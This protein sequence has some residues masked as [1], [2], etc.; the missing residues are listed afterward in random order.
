MSELII[1]L[2]GGL[3]DAVELSNSTKSRL[4]TA[5]ELYTGQSILVVGAGPTKSPPPL[6]S[7]GF[8]VFESVAAVRYLL[9]R[10]VLPEHVLYESSSY[11]TI[12][13]A[14]FARVIHFDPAGYTK[15]VIITSAFHLP[16]TKVIFDWIFGLDITRC[17]ELSYVPAYDGHFSP[18]ALAT[19][20][21]KENDRMT[22]LELLMPQM[23]TLAELHRWLFNEHEAY[24]VH[25]QPLP[26]SETTLEANLLLQRD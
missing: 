20:Q 24:S 11:D 18:K 21:H 10:G 16:R 1:V 12:G 23:T 19:H 26:M 6:N 13:N 7:H 14:Y 9:K 17:P 25:L 5:L 15:A 3:K 4:E 22:D 8:P 2:G